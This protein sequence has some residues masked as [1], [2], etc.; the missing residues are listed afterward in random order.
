MFLDR[1]PSSVSCRHKCYLEDVVLSRCNQHPVGVFCAVGGGEHP[2]GICPMDLNFDRRMKMTAAGKMVQEVS[3]CRYF[4]TRST[5][6]AIREIKQNDCDLNS[7]AVKGR[8]CEPGMGSCA[9]KPKFVPAVIPAG[10]RI[11]KRPQRLE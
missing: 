11:Q 7:Q 3:D 10:N 2:L 4:F 5:W 9:P 6:I 1:E 8:D